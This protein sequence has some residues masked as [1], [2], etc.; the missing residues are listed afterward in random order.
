MEE[1][2]RVPGNRSKFLQYQTCQRGL[3]VT[4]IA[5]ATLRNMPERLS[6]KQHFCVNVTV[7][8]LVSREVFRTLLF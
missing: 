2:E 3:W 5:S 1:L 6:R 8:R 7:G 4:A